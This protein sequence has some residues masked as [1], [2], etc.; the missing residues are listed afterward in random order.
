MK[1]NSIKKTLITATSAVIVMVCGAV[2]LFS[3]LVHEDLYLEVVRGDL[4]GLSENMSHDLLP[5]L[6]DTPDIVNL[7]TLLLRLDSYENVKYSVIFDSSW[8]QLQRYIGNANGSGFEQDSL[9][10]TGEI[11]ALPIGITV[12]KNELIA[13]KRIGEKSYPLGYLLIVIDV[14]GPLDR[15]KASLLTKVLPL[16][17]IVIILGVLGSMWLH[18][19][20]LNPLS[21]LSGL[22]RTIKRTKDY[23]L[24]VDV[25][26]RAEVAE[27][28]RDINSMME[29]I[30][31][32]SQQNFQYNKKLLEQQH[33]LEK[34]AN[35]DA[36]TGL[37]NRQ[38]FI[39]MLRHALAT[40]ER[41]GKNL[42]LM[43]FD[44][45]RFKDINDAHGHETGDQVLIE[46]SQR[47]RNFFR[48]GDVVSR[49]GGDEFLILLQN[50][51]NEHVLADLADRLIQH[52]S[53]PYMINGWELH[54]GAS[55]GIAKARDSNFD[56]N[57]F[58]SHAD[59]AM[60]RSKTTS[61]G[62]KTLF[63]PALMEESKRKLQI[64][65]ALIPAIRNDEFEVFYQAKVSPNLETVGFE[66]LL[67][68]QSAELGDVPP[69]S[70]IP[71]AEQSGKVRDLTR[72]VVD[73]VCRD[74]P[75][76]QKKSSPA[77]VV[78]INLSALDIK[79]KDTITLVKESFEK[80]GTAPGS[81]EFEITESA[82]LEN[83]EIAKETINALQMLG[84]SL[85]LDDFGAGYSSFAGLT[86]IQPNTLKID[87]Q[88]VDSIGL[89]E[90][91]K[92]V[93]RTILQMAK[94]LNMKICAEGV[95]TKQQADFFIAN[96]CDQLQGF[97]FSKPVPLS[98]IKSAENKSVK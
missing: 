49:L 25:S 87:K 47:L 92:L 63:V 78:S 65:N 6:A 81:I 51:P 48:E 79:S 41:E 64:A 86:R 46:V 45:D 94:L 35:F 42:V 12:V 82:Y 70:F 27:L 13:L 53:M 36:L 22:A 59:M 83:Y 95:E 54:L 88:F 2:L 73:R 4:E 98:L 3:I 75:E 52:L 67:R 17:L 31:E 34:L 69:E 30:Q 89:S 58:I 84:S 77:I 39:E 80:Y 44:L 24:R 16:T 37:P 43:Y 1:F 32:Q 71:V 60:Y 85:A 23:S 15:S 28:S 26:G 61:R 97:L 62:T 40:A 90:R 56:I 74:L 20:L 57:E 10:D 11:K 33:D 9:I 19:H 5:L 55:V 50:Q 66:A 72:W 21:K 93:T 14:K 29:T 68:W 96:N 91:T 38:F 18:S 8:Q 7:M 76:I